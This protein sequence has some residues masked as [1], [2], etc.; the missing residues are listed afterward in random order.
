MLCVFIFFFQFFL[1]SFIVVSRRHVIVGCL[2]TL[3]SQQFDVLNLLCRKK[4][5]PT[6]PQ[7]NARRASVWA[8]NTEAWP[9]SH[10]TLLHH[11]PTSNRCVF[12]SRGFSGM[13]TMM[14]KG[15]L[16]RS[17]SQSWIRD[18]VHGQTLLGPKITYRHIALHFKTV[19]RFANSLS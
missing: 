7:H 3:N 8:W 15:T 2:K 6:E 13:Q 9:H 5:S 12:S 4:S 1:R 18:C 17:P 16:L 11:S 14:E 19:F 10:Q